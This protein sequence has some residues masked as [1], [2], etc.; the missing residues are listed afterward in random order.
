[1]PPLSTVHP[2]PARMAPELA[3][4]SL[5]L[6]PRG[7]RVI[8]PM[9]GSGTVMR[10]AVEAG[11]EC[12]GFDID[13]LSVLM[14]KVWTARIDVS[15]VHANAERLVETAR[16]LSD[17]EVEYPDDSET[18]NFM[19]YWFAP[20]QRDALGRLAAAMRRDDSPESDLLAV[21][22]SRLII[23]KEMMASLAKDTSHSRPHKVNETNEFDVYS[24][25]LRSARHVAK[26]L[27]PDKIRAR[28]DIRLGDARTLDGVEDSSFDLAVTSPPYLN[29]IDYMRGHKMT[30]VWLGYKLD[31]LRKVRSANIGAE[32]ILPE[33]TIDVAP[34]I[35]ESERSRLE[36][37]HIGW[38]RRYAADM[39]MALGQLKRIVKPE[40]GVVMVIGNSFL[41][42][43]EIDNAG[44]I[45]SLAESAGFDCVGRFSREIPARRRYLPPPVSDGRNSLD[46]RMR[47]ET[48]LTFRH[49]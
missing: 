42:G 43:A 30:L 24:G 29:A 2:F 40:G 11:I 8:D 13:P 6:V 7:G 15:E 39:K 22:F 10:L 37:R 23:S 25:F 9:C 20:R 36:A 27:A 44:I 1:M 46:F 18:E 17:D 16:A 12:A 26:R 35:R 5:A 31:E 41:R 34:F 48:A 19:A 33:S 14:S 32:R 3:G 28:A 21:A 38:T 49:S 4:Q 45:E 47:R